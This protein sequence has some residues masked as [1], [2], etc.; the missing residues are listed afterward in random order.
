[1]IILCQGITWVA[2][3]LIFLNTK[4]PNWLLFLLNS[5]RNMVWH[6]WEKSGNVSPGFYA[7]SSFGFSMPYPGSLNGSIVLLRFPM[8]SAPSPFRHKEQNSCYSSG[9]K[10][11]S[12]GAWKSKNG[13]D[14]EE[15]YSSCLLEEFK[16]NKKWCFELW[17]IVGHVFSS[18]ILI[19]TSVHDLH[20]VYFI[21]WN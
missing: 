15:R 14:I 7:I 3:F 16:N 17:D 20:I 19:I 5:S 21:K 11:S 4:K 9:W 10:S 6:I 1:M 13:G 2:L 12:M 18:G 8:E